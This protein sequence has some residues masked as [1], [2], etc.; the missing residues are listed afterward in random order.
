MT[1]DKFS[2]LNLPNVY[3]N[4]KSMAELS[5]SP[6]RDY[7]FPGLLVQSIYSFQQK[8]RAA[9]MFPERQIQKSKSLNLSKILSTVITNGT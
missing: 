4:F 8:L 7:R 1:V 3:L 2:S 6:S 5:L 9:F